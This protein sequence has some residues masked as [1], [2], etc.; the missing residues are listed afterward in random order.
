MPGRRAIC[1]DAAPERVSANGSSGRL[2]KVRPEE[3]SPACSTGIIHKWTKDAATA[4][5]GSG[6][7]PRFLRLRSCLL[8]PFAAGTESTSTCRNTK[9]IYMRAAAK[10]VA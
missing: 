1:M 2:D 7:N 9:L 5:P 4:T 3:L 8:V 10:L 6:M